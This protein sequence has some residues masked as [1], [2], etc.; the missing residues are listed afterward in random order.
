MALI[1]E[2]FGD[3]TRGTSLSI[4]LNDICRRITST[5]RHVCPK[6]SRAG[7]TNGSR[8]VKCRHKERFL[9]SRVSAKVALLG[10]SRSGESSVSRRIAFR[11][12]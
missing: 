12:K 5:I 8:G 3:T 10:E 6:E 1:V 2:E 4:S 7:A 11:W 9:V